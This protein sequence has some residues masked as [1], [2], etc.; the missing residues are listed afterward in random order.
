MFASSAADLTLD[1]VDYID[2]GTGLETLQFLI[3][4]AASDRLIVKNCNF[5]ATTAGAS[6][7]LWIA[8]VG[9]DSPKII[10]N[11]FTLTLNNAA[12]SSCVNGDASVRSFLIDRNTIVQL[13]GATMTSAILMTNGATGMARDNMV[14]SAFT[15][16]DSSIDVGNA[17]FACENYALNTPDASGILE[18]NADT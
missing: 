4:T 11:I 15:N 2:P 5:N 12:T 9:C 14:A 3:T 16:I 8:L 10:D 1:H 6:A 13:G 17:G 18:P 7:Q